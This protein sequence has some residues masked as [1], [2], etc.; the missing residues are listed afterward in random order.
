MILYM[1]APFLV[2]QSKS[3]IDFIREDVK[4]PRVWLSTS[5]ALCYQHFFLNE[6]AIEEWMEAENTNQAHNI[7]YAR[8]LPLYMHKSTGVSMIKALQQFRDNDNL[9]EYI[10]TTQETKKAWIEGN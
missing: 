10:R 3:Q 9:D 5:L 1:M 8:V 4:L 7:F 6:K 2:T